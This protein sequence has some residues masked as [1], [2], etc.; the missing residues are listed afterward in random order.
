VMENYHQKDFERLKDKLGWQPATKPRKLAFTTKPLEFGKDDDVYEGF[1]RVISEVAQKSGSNE[2]FICVHGFNNSFAIAADRAARIAYN[3]ERP[4]ILFSWPSTAKLLQY[5]VDSGNNEWSQEHFNRL[6]EE[7]IDLRE[8]TGLKINIVAHSMGN[9][10]VV[11]S[12]PI[13][14]GKHLFEQVFL[15]DPD[16][17]AE[18]FF[19]YVARYLRS[20]KKQKQDPAEVT[21]V[22][23][24]YSRKDKAL[25][26]AQLIFGGYTRLGQGADTALESLFNPTQVPGS[27]QNATKKL[28][29]KLNPVALTSKVPQPAAQSARQRLRD[30]FE[31]IDFTAID[32]GFVGHTIPY[33]MIAN[34]WSTGKPGPGLAI[35]SEEAGQVNRM[36]QVIAR[37]FKQNQRIAELG[38]CEKIVL[39]KNTSDRAGGQ[40][41]SNAE[42]YSN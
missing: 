25:P 31:W 39:V 4:V 30:A 28:A 26:I 11:R 33:E 6:I 40:A 34:L 41:I 2:I 18:T 37:Y 22:R 16:Y 3:V 32:H 7:L 9:R 14:A 38:R 21:K 36:T 23:I 10:L 27:V 13:A 24:L 42:K 35:A 20:V 8:R 17:D 1:A 5:T 12:I 29:T 19:H 15:V